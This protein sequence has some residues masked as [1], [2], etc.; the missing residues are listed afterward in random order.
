MNGPERFRVACAHHL[1]DLPAEHVAGV[2]GT[3]RDRSD[4]P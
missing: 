3:D 2:P 4:Q 1:V